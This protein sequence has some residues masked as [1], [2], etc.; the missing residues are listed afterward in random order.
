MIVLAVEEAHVSR[1][2]QN[3]LK[4]PDNQLKVDD[5]AKI[6]GCW[7]ALSKQ[8]LADDLVG[9]D[10]AMQDTTRRGLL[11]SYRNSQ[12]RQDTQGQLKAD[13]L[14]VPVCCGGLSGRGRIR[15]RSL[16]STAKPS[17]WMAA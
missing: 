9:D 2:I 4:D 16:V 13:C 5:A 17:M 14:D 3:L 15:S 11:P 12:G 8:G 10:Q 1:R 7:K 6:I